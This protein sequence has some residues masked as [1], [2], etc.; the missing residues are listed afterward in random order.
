VNYA[1]AVKPQNTL[2][3]G[4]LL[5]KGEDGERR[6]REERERRGRGDEGREEFVLYP[7]KKKRK[8]GA[9]DRNY[10]IEYYLICSEK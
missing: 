2:Y 7:R 3:L 1:N 10:K 9:Y 8:V 4:G 6:G 5:L